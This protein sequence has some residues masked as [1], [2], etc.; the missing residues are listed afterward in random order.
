MENNA[1][2]TTSSFKDYH[3]RIDMSEFNLRNELKQTKFITIQ[4]MTRRFFNRKPVPKTILIRTDTINSI[5]IKK[6]K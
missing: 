3:V 1:I 6:E 4:T 5:E 2:I